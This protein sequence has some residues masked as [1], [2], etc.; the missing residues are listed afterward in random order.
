MLVDAWASYF[1][2]AKQA[3]NGELIEDDSF[4]LNQILDDLERQGGDASSLLSD[5]E[6]DVPDDWEEPETWGMDTLHQI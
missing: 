1:A 6:E 5:L 2:K 4:D 3:G